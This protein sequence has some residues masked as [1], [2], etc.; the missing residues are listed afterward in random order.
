MKHNLERF[1]LGAALVSASCGSGAGPT[2]KDP[3]PVPQ[4]ETDRALAA[5]QPA[6]LVASDRL[7]KLDQAI[8]TH[9]ERVATRR[10]YLMTDKPLYQPGETIW[11]RADLRATGTL[12]GARSAGVKLELISPR[13]A[14]VA[15]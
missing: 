9:F 7:G 6:K 4:T 12:V 2:A 11:V 14:V 10:G 1:L 8:V 3:T 5:L 15:Q 13:G